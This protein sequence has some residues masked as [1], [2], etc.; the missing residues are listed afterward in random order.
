MSKDENSDGLYEK[1]IYTSSDTGNY[2]KDGD[3]NAFDVANY[4][5]TIN[6]LTTG[7]YKFTFTDN[8]GCVKDKEFDIGIASP[9]NHE[10]L[11]FQNY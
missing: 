7:K 8:N 5:I 11:N 4:T 1:N 10:L 3:S 2:T 9:L 6:D